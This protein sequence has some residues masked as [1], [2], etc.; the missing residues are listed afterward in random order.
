MHMR[1]VLLIGGSGFIGSVIARKLSAAGVRVVV[2]TRNRERAKHLILL[3]TVEVVQAR[4]AEPDDLKRLVRGM[5]AV[6][7]LAGVLHSRGGDPYGPQ[8]KA[9]HVD[10]AGAVAQACVAAK[11]PRLIHFSSLGAAAG[12]P[13]MYLRS[14]AAGETAVETEMRA[15]NGQVAVTI[16]RPSV[17]FG[18]DDSFINMF[19]RMQALAPFIPLGRADSRLQPVHVEDVAQAAVNALT[20]PA[21]FGHAYDIAGP[22]VYTLRQL[23]Q[24]AGQLSGHPRLVIALPGPL[25]YLQA[26][27]ME[28]LPAP[29]ISRD[30]LDSLKSDSVMAGGVAPELGVTPVAMEA[31]V[32]LYLAHQ[33]PR[34]RLMKLRDHAGR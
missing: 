34:Q 17:V 9:V 14:K 30:N 22:R 21:T 18:E 33:L 15:A 23:M 5:D 26:W 13:S 32:P 25:A 19:A 8:F 24:Y 31:V 7:N 20:N 10:L 6:I 29:P 12:A 28:F 1:N 4:V 27:L 3:P 2:P 11:V 16:L